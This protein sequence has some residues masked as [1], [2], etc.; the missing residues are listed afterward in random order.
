MNDVVYMLWYLDM[1]S[2]TTIKLCERLLTCSSRQAHIYSASD[3][4]S[5]LPTPIKHSSPG[6]ISDIT[7]PST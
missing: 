3:A 6:P 5:S 7:W 4:A 1:E 2:L